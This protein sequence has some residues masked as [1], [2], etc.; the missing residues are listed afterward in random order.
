[1][2]NDR[3]KLLEQ[4]LAE[5]RKVRAENERLKAEN[6]RFRNENTDLGA[7]VSFSSTRLKE[8]EGMI[9]DLKAESARKDVLIAEQKAEAARKDT[10]IAEQ[11][12]EAAKKDALISE[13]KKTLEKIRKYL[14]DMNIMK[15]KAVDALFGRSSAKTKEIAEKL[16][17]SPEAKAPEKYVHESGKRGRKPDAKNFCWDSSRY[18]AEEKTFESTE[19]ETCEDCG[20]KL[21]FDHYETREKISVVP[22]HLRKTLLK[23]AVYHCAGCGKAVYAKVPKEDTDCFGASACT[24]SLAGFL[25]MLSCGLFLPGQRISSLFSY[26]GTPVSKELISRYLIR[27]SDVLSRF[28]DL[29][30]RQALRSHVL[31]MDET[32][33]NALDEKDNATNYVWSMTTGTA[34]KHQISYYMYA[35]SREYANLERMAGGY[36]GVIVSDSYGAYFGENIHQLCM[37]H[38][39]KYLF[40]YLRAAG[41]D[42]PSEDVR[43]V[44]ELFEMCNRIF[45]KEREISALAPEERRERR[46]K[47]LR[48]LLDA[49]FE[50]AEKYY[51]PE[52]KDSKNRAIGYGLSNRSLYYAAVDDPEVPITNNRAEQTM[53]KA[54]MK[55]ASS[56]FSASKGGAESTCRLLTVV[57]TARLNGLSP[58]R[59]I[60]HLL[61][62]FEDLDDDRTAAKHLPWS[63]SLPGSIRFTE[64]EIEKA[65]AEQ[66]MIVKK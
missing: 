27:T 11:K 39:R 35:K 65:K 45:E 66:K 38:L 8:K 2:K 52:T 10:I 15:A 62:H 25:S 55:R 60:Q 9:S 51:D 18:M 14:I 36:E 47:E 6:D 54:V 17:S 59:Y 21:V 7:Q 32:T 58:D 63:S 61:E 50:T 30:R 42:V 48:P 28:C 33:W 3:E 4:A 26:A 34:E 49:Y 16:I 37:S 31:H 57:Q 23:I 24:P 5:L 29:L 53:R 56:M 13:Q 46:K 44:T 41:K 43:Q 19:K 40:D 22:Q 1:M 12:S 20:G 64:K